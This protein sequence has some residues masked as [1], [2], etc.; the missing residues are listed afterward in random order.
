MGMKC[1]GIDIGGTSVKIGLFESTGE[2]I[3]KWEVRTRS[4]DGGINILPDVAASIRS[5]VQEMGL[6]LKRDIAGAGMGIPG[7]VLSDGYVEVCVNLGWHNNLGG[8]PIRRLFKGLKP[9]NGKNLLTRI[10]GAQH[11]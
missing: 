9:F 2:L 11:F 4:E 1:I 3:D 10:G 7:P 5:K 8:F 6:D